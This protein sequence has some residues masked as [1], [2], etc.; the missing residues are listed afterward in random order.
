MARRRLTLFQPP[1]EEKPPSELTKNITPVLDLVLPEKKPEVARTIRDKAARLVK[2]AK[3]VFHSRFPGAYVSVELLVVEPAEYETRYLWQ[4]DS[5]QK[6]VPVRILSKPM[7]IQNIPSGMSLNALLDYLQSCC[8]TADELEQTLRANQ[9][10][11]TRR[12]PDFS[13]TAPF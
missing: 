11:L 9:E 6:V 3:E 8:E 4:P 5:R 13:S 12:Y 10:T 2:A 7:Q 1:P